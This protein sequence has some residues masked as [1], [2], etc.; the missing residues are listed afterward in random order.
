VCRY[1]N[2][3]QAAKRMEEHDMHAEMN[4]FKTF[5]NKKNILKR[6]PYINS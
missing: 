2:G 6:E 3:T 1:W 4:Y 5:L